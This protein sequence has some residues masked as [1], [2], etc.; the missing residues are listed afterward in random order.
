MNVIL[1]FFKPFAGLIFLLHT[2]DFWV[3]FLP[4]S[5]PT[6]L[7][8]AP[9]PPP[10]RSPLSQTPPPA[11]RFAFGPNSPSILSCNHNQKYLHFRLWSLQNFAQKKPYPHPIFAHLIARI[12]IHTHTH[13]QAHAQTH[14]QKRTGNKKIQFVHS[15]KGYCD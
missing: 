13:K 5:P 3:R 12:K 11:I 9:A 15:M 4:S 2:K 14:T 10:L 6:P 1:S 8:F 7:R